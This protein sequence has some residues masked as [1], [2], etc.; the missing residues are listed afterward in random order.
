[1]KT[2]KEISREE[3]FS[4]LDHLGDGL[5]VFNEAGNLLLANHMAQKMF[6]IEE[7]IREL[8]NKPV[9]EFSKHSPLNN[10]F[11]L[12]GKEIKEFFRKELEIEKNFILEITSSFI[13]REGEK[14]GTLVVLH[15]ITRKKT[16]ERT[17]TEFVTISAHQLRTPLSAIQW[18]LERLLQEKAGELNEEQ[19]TLIQ[20]AFEDNKRMISLINNLLNLVKIEEGRH[21]YKLEAARFDKVVDSVVKF[22]KEEIKKKKIKFEIQVLD[23]KLP[24]IR[25]DIEQI[26]F[27][28]QNLLDNAVRYTPL[29][30]RITIIL[31]L[32]EEELWFAIE[33]TGIG[34][35]KDQQ[36][37]ILKKFFRASNAVKAETEGNGTGLFIAK[38]I[39]EAHGGKIWFESEE[40]QGTTFCFTLPVN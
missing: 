24:K 5:M 26:S 4:I 34:I 10:L 40:N 19:K 13:V 38:N 22:Y 33:D 9:E 8:L 23:K 7:K 3:I 32:K 35:P 6:G 18:M 12:L 39:I 36:G 27:V 31:R 28:V 25:M 29:G 14:I 37:S 21:V 1:M 17:K 11:Y 16:I 30:G 2:Q 15:D 20:K